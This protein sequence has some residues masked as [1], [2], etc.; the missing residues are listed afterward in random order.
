MNLV[1]VTRTLITVFLFA[2]CSHTLRCPSLP[3]GE[4]ADAQFARHAGA[5]KMGPLSLTLVGDLPTVGQQA[6]NFTAVDNGLKDKQLED[7]LGRVLIISAVPSLDTPVCDGQTRH[8]HREAQR[9][10]DDVVV[11]T[12][13]MDL[14]FAQKR[15]CAAAGIDTVVTLSDYKYRDFAKRY[16]VYI[17]ELALVGR[18][19]FVVDQQGVVRYVQLVES[20]GDAPEY[21]PVLEEVSRLLQ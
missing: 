3:A 9:L 15:W 12:L 21:A 20:V 11:L 4:S 19:V 7:Y 13:S 5:T 10:G 14:P 16:G 18:A 17:D 2:G 8:F 6:P 1:K